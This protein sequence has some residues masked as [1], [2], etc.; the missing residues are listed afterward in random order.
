MDVL[1]PKLSRWV[2]QYINAGSRRFVRLEGEV[3]GSDAMRSMWR[4]VGG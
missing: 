3:D 1:S 4:V 2:R